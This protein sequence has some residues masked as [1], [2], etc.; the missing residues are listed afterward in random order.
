[1]PSIGNNKPTETVKV[2]LVDDRQDNLLALEAVLASPDYELIKLSSGQEALRYLLSEEPA[3]ILMDVQMPDLDGFETANLIKQNERTREIPIIFIT[4]INKDERYVSKGYAYGAVDYIYKPFDA[5]ILI[6]KVRAFADLYRKNRRLLEAERR[7]RETAITEREHRLAELELRAL[8][9]ERAEQK[10][11][12]DLVEGIPEGVVWAALPESFMFVFV[13]QAAETLFGYP[14]DQWLT[15]E[16]FFLSRLPSEEREA[17][18]DGVRAIWETGKSFEREHR[19]LK[20]DG[21][22]A[23]LKTSVRIHRDPENDAV[24]LR[25]LSTDITRLKEAERMLERAKNRSELLAQASLALAKSVDYQT[26]LVEVADLVAAHLHANL[27]VFPWTKASAVPDT[28]K[29]LR[30]GM[31]VTELRARNNSLGLLAIEPRGGGDFARDELQGIA[32]DL[33]NRVAAAIDNAA[34]FKRAQDAIKVR[35]EFISIASHELKTPITPLKLQTQLLLRMADRQPESEWKRDH[36][37]GMLRSSNQQIDRLTRLVDDLLDMSR[38]GQ[39]KLQLSFAEFDLVALVLEIL[40]RFE[41]QLARAG[42]QVEA[43]LPESL[44]VCW[45]S[46]RIEQVL[47]NLLANAVKYAPGKPVSVTLSQ[48][49]NIVVLSIKDNGAGI[50]KTDQARIFK[51]FERVGSSTAIAGLGLGLYIVSQIVGEHGG[52]VFVES[53]LGHGAKFTVKIPRQPIRIAKAAKQPALPAAREAR[54]G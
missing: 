33:A 31:V 49:N 1:M 12:R 25:G 52:K 50:S 51:R 3:V 7:L 13:S 24:E 5:H 46:F 23:W 16:N 48:E 9:R 47:I 40:K 34:L 42:I 22:T 4:A 44:I 32:D 26:N 30:Q 38:M 35:E 14:V 2:L 28:D 6:S 39:G 21:T 8:K 17:F 10:K 45:D 41:E 20:R 29:L 43:S 18:R 54:G 19:F 27:H 36:I 11:Y 53:S 15:E 37:V